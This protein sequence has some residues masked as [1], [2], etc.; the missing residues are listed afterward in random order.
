VPPSKLKKKF[1]EEKYNIT[2]EFAMTINNKQIYV[3]SH[4]LDGAINDSLNRYKSCITNNQKGNI[5]SFRLRYLK[6]NKRNQILKIEKIAFKKT[7]FYTSVLGK[8]MQCSISDFNYSEN[9]KTTATLK[10]SKDDDEFNLFIKYKK[11]ELSKRQEY[12]ERYETISIDLGLR[13][14]ATGL[15]SNRIVLIGTNMMKKNK[16]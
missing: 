16:K 15:T 2:N 9:I 8:K 11:P 4:L 1:K 3:N 10:Y 13:K 5:K 7:G 12:K 6:P 14:F